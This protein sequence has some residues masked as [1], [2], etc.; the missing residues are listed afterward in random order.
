MESKLQISPYL[1]NDQYDSN[2]TKI[3]AP[4]PVSES[5]A[6]EIMPLGTGHL[7]G[8]GGYKM[9]KSQVQNF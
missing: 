6:V 5:G 1:S 9:G 8:G 4:T 3:L 7:L 2:N